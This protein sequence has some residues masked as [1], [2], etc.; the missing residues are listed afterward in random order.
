MTYFDLYGYR[1]DKPYSLSSSSDLL[2]ALIS[3]DEAPITTK[4]RPILIFI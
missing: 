3:T 4:F 2:F 1:T